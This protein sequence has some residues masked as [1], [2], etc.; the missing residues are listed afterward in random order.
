[1]AVDLW[2]INLRSGGGREF[3]WGLRKGMNSGQQSACWMRVSGLVMDGGRLDS[4]HFRSWRVAAK[5]RRSGREN[6]SDGG[7]PSIP[8]EIPEDTVSA[9]DSFEQKSHNLN[10]DWRTFRANLVAHEKG[11][12]RELNDTNSTKRSGKLG[13]KWAH[14]I[15]VPE[16]GCI[17]IA[18]D[19]LDG[20]RTFER[21]VILMLRIG[22]R[23][24]RDGPFG[25][26]L[27]R[28]LHKRIKHMKPTNPDLATTFADCP[29]YFGGP[30][31]A[32]MFLLRAGESSSVPNFEQVLP[33]VCFGAR[34]GLGEA[35][36]L[37][38]NGRFR[39]QDFQFFVGYAGWQVDQLREEIESGYWIVAACSSD[40]I[41]VGSVDSALGLWEET[42]TL[43]GGQY[44]D[45]SRKAR[46]SDD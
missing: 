10:L 8:D 39:S 29:L 38:K 11:Q 25:V 21:T 28:P 37:V 17:L 33:G 9:D 36:R 46:E 19:K 42:L 35:S 31:E 30:L 40:L 45:M 3:A 22:T 1:M 15:P 24:P 26:I 34:N 18:T 16:T 6:S 41:G 2:S 43:M 32:S 14:P 44:S 27:N 23:D 13:S 4:S 7:D 12:G 20:V 5:G